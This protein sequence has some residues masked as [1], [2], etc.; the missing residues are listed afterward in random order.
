MHIHRVAAFTKD[1]RGGNPAGVV[2]A[3]TLP[4]PA[5]MQS[6]AATVGY[7]ETAF[8]APDGQGSWTVRYYSPETEVP[9]CGHATIAL[10]AVLCETHGPGRYR[11]SLANA[12]IEV[13]SGMQES[14]R[15]SALRSPPTRSAPAD[16]ELLAKAFEIFGYSE[17]DLDPD[18]PACE[19]NGGTNHLIIALRSR[20]ALARMHYD[21]ARG[22]AFMRDHA[23]GTVA[24]IFRESERV[25][26]ARNAF[27]IGGVLE[28]PATGAAAAALAGMLRD[29]GVL[30]DGEIVIYQ[31]EDMGQP[32]RIEAF[33][34]NE[35][36][37]P[38]QV[39]GLSN[40]ILDEEG[41]V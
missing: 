10:G 39:R 30:H 22:R 12:E 14:V 15:W 3:A 21:L 40:K 34:T 18:I 9:F 17:A 31:G 26:H 6:I 24:F 16:P 28:D 11:L 29:V 20:A 19:A 5:E 36:G 4:L 32:C 27:A 7:S 8:A 37:S 41:S 25:F 23:I 13:E 33:F 35:A 2:L 1:G 38:V